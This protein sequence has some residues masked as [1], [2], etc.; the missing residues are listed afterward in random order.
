MKSKKTDIKIRI[1]LFDGD[2]DKF[3]LWWVLFEAS[4]LMKVFNT[5]LKKTREGALH[6][7]GT[8]YPDAT[9]D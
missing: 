3:Q 2:R 6:R 5:S 7:Y 8:V 4:G 9:T 1:S